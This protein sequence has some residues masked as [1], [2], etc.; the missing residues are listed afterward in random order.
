MKN[1][2]HGDYQEGKDKNVNKMKEDER[3]REK[4]KT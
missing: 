3:K 2:M 1:P 4:M